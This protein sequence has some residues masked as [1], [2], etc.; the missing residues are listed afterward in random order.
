[1]QALIQFLQSAANNDKALEKR[2]K[3]LLTPKE[4]NEVQHRLAI[5]ELL[6]QGVPQR[7]IAKKLG[8]GIATVTR[9]SRALQELENDSNE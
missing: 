6:K 5:F 1:M 9:G 7:E 2:L 8:V 3:A 4:I